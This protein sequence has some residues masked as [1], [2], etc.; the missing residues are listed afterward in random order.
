MSLNPFDQTLSH[1]RQLGENAFTDNIRTPSMDEGFTQLLARDQH[2]AHEQL[3]LTL[4]WY[5]GHRQA[6]KKANRLSEKRDGHD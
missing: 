6:R 2:T 1:A 4:A 5:D 3:M